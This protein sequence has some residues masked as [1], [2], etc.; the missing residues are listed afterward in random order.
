MKVAIIQSYYFNI[1]EA[2]GPGYIIAYCKKNYI[3]EL[4]FKFYQS[5]FDSDNY[6]I[7]NCKD[8]DIVGFSCTSPTFKHG[9]ELANKLKSIN[10]NI[11][12]V[13]GGYHVSA[14]KEL[15][16]DTCIDQIVVGEG[17]SAFLDILNGNNDRIIYGKRLSFKELPWPDRDTIK[18]ERTVDLC[19]KMTGLRITG[20][21]ANRGCPFR[22]PFCGERCITGTINKSNPIRTREVNDIV[23]EIEFIVNKYKLNY[24][25]FID[26]TFDISPKFVIDFCKEKIKRNLNVEWECMVH[27]GIAKE[28]MFPWLKKANCTQI[29]VG[30]ESGSPKILKEIKKGASIKN[31][32]D[33]FDWGKKYNIKRRAFFLIG[34][35]SETI[36]DIKLTEKLIERINP[37]FFYVTILCPYPGTD[38]YDHEKMKD[39]DWSN[40][41]EYSNDFW[42]TKYFSNQ[43]LKNIQKELIEK[44]KDKLVVWDKNIGP[45]VRMKKRDKE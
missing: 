26:A 24:F 8:C 34:M 12:I 2:I 6:I 44:F 42:H 22:C 45:G 32:L 5:Y 27:A 4:D 16:K 40:A 11:K 13:F 33:V 7:N 28:K 37:D 18:N 35:P 23:N 38:L 20:L 15:I 41:D 29:N 9:I 36:E 3:G 17:E 19:E 30:C 43:D 10:S 21:Q 39:I 31:I 14:L 1:W 25:K